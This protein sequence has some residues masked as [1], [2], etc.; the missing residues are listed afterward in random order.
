MVLAPEY[1][2]AMPRLDE[3]PAGTREGVEA[4]RKTVVGAHVMRT[5]ATLRRAKLP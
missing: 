1:G 3:L 5:Y 2:G 4:L